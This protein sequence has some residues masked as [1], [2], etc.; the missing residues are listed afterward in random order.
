MYGRDI[1]T[2]TVYERIY[3]MCIC[4]YTFFWLNFYDPINRISFVLTNVN[5]FR[6]L[7]RDHGRSV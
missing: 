3:T 6:E 4:I 5:I 2:Q 1:Y 7:I